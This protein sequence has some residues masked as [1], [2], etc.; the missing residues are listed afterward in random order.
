M[1]GETMSDLARLLRQLKRRDARRRGGSELTYRTLAAKT[2]WSAGIIAHYFTGKTLPPTDRFDLLVRLLGA[3]PAEQGRL[4]T[5]RDRIDSLLLVTSRHRLEGLAIDHDVTRIQLDVLAG[6]EASLL[7]GRVLGA[8]RVAAGAEPVRRLIEL[9]GGMPLALRICAAKLAARPRWTIAELVS[10]SEGGDRLGTLSVAGDARSLRAVFASGVRALGPAAVAL[11]RRLGGLP[12]PTFTT[13]PAAALATPAALDELASAHL[14]SEVDSGR[15][16]L[17]DLLKLNNMAL[18]YGRLG[19]IEDAAAMFERALRLY[20]QDNYLPGV[21]LA[22]NNL[23]D[24]YS[25]LGRPARALE[26][27]ERGLSLAQRIGN[28]HLEGGVRQNLGEAALATGDGDGTLAQFLLALEIRHRIGER[29]SEAETSNAIGLLLVSR[30]D[31]AGAAVHFGRALALAR[32]LD[33]RALEEA[34]L[35][36]L[37]EHGPVGDGVDAGG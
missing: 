9:C 4:A 21:A 6:G 12:G 7:L 26:H 3:S 25:L 32:E 22:H 23:G 27:L 13:W 17:H 34:A 35:A 19:R 33:D 14:V 30:G 28:A 1:S 15:Y 8:A 31:G 24:M 18:A 37:R 2:G 11:F 36:R 10:D 20:T 29:R 5:I 16:R